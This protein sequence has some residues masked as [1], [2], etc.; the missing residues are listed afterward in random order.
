[1][2][3]YIHLLPPTTKCNDHDAVELLIDIIHGEKKTTF[4]WR[5]SIE[6]PGLKEIEEIIEDK[7]KEI[8]GAKKAISIMENKMKV[9]DEYRDLITGTGDEELTK[10]VQKTFDDLGIKTERTEPGFVVDLIGNEVAVE[11]TGTAGNIKVDSPKMSQISRFIMQHRKDEKVILV[12]NTHRHL[13][14][15]ERRGK[16]DFTK[17]VTDFLTPMNVCLIT[18]SSLFELWKRTRTGELKKD[19]VKKKLLE[20]S[21]E[22][23]IEN[24]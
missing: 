11:V 22:F 20:K 4:P 9:L 16:E 7:E 6:V 18:S 12:A 3:G 24:M 13:K 17:Q 15:E 5:S 14:P 2:G 10:I 21:G 8:I 1:M 23:K 19:Y